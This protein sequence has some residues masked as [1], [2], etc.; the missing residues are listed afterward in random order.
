MA[1]T[2]EAVKAKLSALNETQEGIVTVAQWIMFHRR[3]A[4]TTT[5][6]WADRLKESS[7]SKRLS[8]IYLANEVVQQSKVRK[9]DNFVQVFSTIIADATIAAYKSA[10]S[11]IQQKL[12]RVVEV[13][14]QRSIFDEAIQKSIETGL[15][16]LDSNRGGKKSLGG[17]LFA[18]SSVP[19][20]LTPLVDQ[21]KAVGN[22]EFTSKQ[23]IAASL[24]EYSKAVGPN[25]VIPSPPMYAAK[26]SNLFKNLST[27]ETA[28]AESIKSRNSLI[29]SLE[30]LITAQRQVV[31]TEEAQ[32]ADV[33]TKR[34]AAE[35]KRRE[36]EDGIMRGMNMEGIADE[37]ERPEFEKL[38]PP[39]M[40]PDAI[41][42][43]TPT[44]TPPPQPMP[45]AAA[46][47]PVNGNGNGKRAVDE[48]PSEVKQD[49]DTKDLSQL[50]QFASTTVPVPAPAA[51]VPA[52][53][54]QQ[55]LLAAITPVTDPRLASQSLTPTDPRLAQR[56]ESTDPRKRRRVE[57]VDEQFAR[58]MGGAAGM[59]G[60][61]D[62]VAAML[63]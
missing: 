45:A 3:H 36:V 31:A 4:E 55:D 22:A 5:Q 43:L 56:G 58:S 34:V 20:V 11:D 40:D 62:E 52:G 48:E 23:A 46:P 59:E 63:G 39:P 47:E 57:S 7:A 1:Y 28:V 42:S 60:V 6:I 35:K 49:S 33:K 54:S 24:N 10:P 44:N 8:L 12:R 61:D 29:A 27:A 41:E 17:A 21:A 19:Q 51:A 9:K 37:P 30:S 13:W 38:T 15:D 2:Q 18:E 16:Q 53:P 32:L 25:A 14:R 26:L 50:S